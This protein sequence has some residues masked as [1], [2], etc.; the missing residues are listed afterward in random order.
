MNPPVD[1]REDTDLASVWELRKK[2]IPFSLFVHQEPIHSLEE[3]AKARSQLPNQVIRSLLFRLAEGQFAL[4]LVAGPQ[5]IPWKN[6]RSFFQQ[7]RLTQAS[8]EEVLEITGYRIGPVSPFGL[9][10]PVPVY[11][12]SGVLKEETL[13]M[14]SG[15]AGTAILI[16]MEDLQRALPRAEIISL[17]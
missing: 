1:S 5:Q 10:N 9:A 2:G 13:S 6:L 11:I 7:R 4:V 8:T 16:K 12:E 17:F 3:A 14:G 15:R